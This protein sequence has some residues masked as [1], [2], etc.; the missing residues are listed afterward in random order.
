MLKVLVYENDLSL[1]MKIKA[2]LS[3]I[4]LIDEA[5]IINDEKACLKAIKDEH[6]DLFIL[7]INNRPFKELLLKTLPDIINQPILS[8]DP[9]ADLSGFTKVVAISLLDGKLNLI[10]F[11]SALSDLVP[12][13]I[14]L[15]EKPLLIEEYIPVKMGIFRKIKNTPCDVHIKLS[16][17]KYVKI[18]NEDEEVQTSFLDRYQS[19]N[20]N[21]FYIKKVDFYRCSDQLFANVLPDVKNFESKTDYFSQSQQVIKD[22]ILEIGINENVIKLTDELVESALSEYKDPNLLSLLNKFKYSE[23]RYPYDHSVFTSI[24]AVAMCEKFEWR[25]RQLMQKIVFASFFHD[26]GFTNSKLAFFENNVIGNKDLTKDQKNEILN[27][28]QKMVDLLG[29]NK[30]ISSEVLSIIGKHHEAQG[31][32]SYPLGLT[33]ASLSILECIFIVAHQFTNELYKIAFRADK[34]P[35]AIENVV[36]FANTGNLKQ[37]RNV[38]L[39]VVSKKV[40][41]K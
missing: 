10:Q 15:D 36:S 37:V 21:E 29:Q 38:F 16:R 5:K 39:T 3:S 27:H 9:T 4:S 28:S 6:Y 12:S 2:L 14:L 33:S 13:D 30:S 23:D 26:F 19:K 7:E 11:L 32:N 24:L 8:L 31:E 1:L 34:I 41:D 18:I 17:D 22:V 25:N 40:W 20:I 35:K